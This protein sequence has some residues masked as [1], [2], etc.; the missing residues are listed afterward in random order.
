MK[1]TRAGDPQ[2]PGYGHLTFFP[3]AAWRWWVRG[4]AWCGGETEV[5]RRRKTQNERQTGTVHVFVLR[6]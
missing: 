1:Y 3:G 5:F 2:S 6:Q 4:V